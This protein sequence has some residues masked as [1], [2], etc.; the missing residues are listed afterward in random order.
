MNAGMLDR[1]VQFM[2][3]TISTGSFGAEQV[4]SDHGAPVW[5]SKRDISDAERLRAAQADA[6][7]TTRFVVRWS[8]FAAGIT[9]ADA[10]VCEGRTYNIRGLKEVG[11]RVWVEITAEAS[12]A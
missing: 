10:L 2:R 1:R 5:A 7:I 8:A 12:A 4:W 9:P 11:R 3:V 6:S